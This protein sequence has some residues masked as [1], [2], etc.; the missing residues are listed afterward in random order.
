MKAT[1]YLH[2]QPVPIIHRDIKPENILV[3]GDVLKLADFGSCN[4]KDKLMKETVCGTPE[5]LAPEMLNNQGHDE[6]IDIWCIGILLYELLTGQ[7]PF[8][9]P[10]KPKNGFN[11]KETLMGIFD[12]I[13]VIFI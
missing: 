10:T 9:S 13:K 3:F 7:T 6:K 5:Y 12:T 2:S 11:Q 4:I 8:N 1:K